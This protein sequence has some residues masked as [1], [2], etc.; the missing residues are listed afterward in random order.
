[1]QASV[2]EKQESKACLKS[3]IE[4]ST[5]AGPS[6]LQ[7]LSACLRSLKFL[8]WLLLGEDGEWWGDG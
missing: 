8:S 4:Y 7:T 2:Q 3:L 1:M 5:S 6:I